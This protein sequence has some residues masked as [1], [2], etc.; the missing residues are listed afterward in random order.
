[1]RVRAAAPAAAL[2]LACA[3]ACAGHGAGGSGSQED[4]YGGENVVCEWVTRPQQVG[5]GG[6]V[7][8]RPER[9]C[10]PVPAARREPP[11]VQG[12]VKPAPGGPPRIEVE[13]EERK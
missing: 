11:E 12:D 3:L 1:M 9:Q 8:V 4:D 2:G 6:S 13:S 10:R 7:R 5:A